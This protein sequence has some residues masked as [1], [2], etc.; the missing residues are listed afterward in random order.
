MQWTWD[1]CAVENWQVHKDLISHSGSTKRTVRLDCVN[2]TLELPRGGGVS[3]RALTFPPRPAPH[4]HHPHHHPISNIAEISG[5]LRSCSI[6]VPGQFCPSP[7]LHRGLALLAWASSTCT[8]SA[9]TTPTSPPVSDPES[10]SATYCSASSSTA[11]SFVQLLVF[12]A[13]SRVWL[14]RS[15]PAY[16]HTTHLPTH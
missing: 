11:V 2:V 5:S 9:P 15:A 7:V 1:W 14:G 13:A 3:L 12:A 10:T 6:Q 16:T 8:S 4:S